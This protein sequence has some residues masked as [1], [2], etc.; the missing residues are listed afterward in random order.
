MVLKN[1]PVGIKILI[2]IK[3]GYEC[4]CQGERI[5]A[6]P[7]ELLFGLIPFY[8]ILILTA[9]LPKVFAWKIDLKGIGNINAVRYPYPTGITKNAKS[10]L[11]VHEW[12]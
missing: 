3:Y 10:S 9:I 6:S 2:P 4:V 8:T 11:Y 7:S 1:L 12:Y 5:S